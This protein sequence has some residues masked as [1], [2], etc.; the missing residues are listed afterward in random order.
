MRTGAGG[1]DKPLNSYI[2]DVQHMAG[3]IQKDIVETRLN[4]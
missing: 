4:R 2:C 3:N 1:R